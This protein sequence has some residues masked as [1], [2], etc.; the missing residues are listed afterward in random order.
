VPLERLTAALPQD[1]LAIPGQAHRTD[2]AAGIVAVIACN[3]NFSIDSRSGAA[4]DIR[5][6]RALWRFTAK[7]KWVEFLGYFL[8]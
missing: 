6:Y 3:N 8:A 2:H 7:I 4:R 5:N 1:L